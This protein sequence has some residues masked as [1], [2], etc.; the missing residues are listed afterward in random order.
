[1]NAFQCVCEVRAEKVFIVWSQSRIIDAQPPQGNT[2]HQDELQARG[3]RLTCFLTVCVRESVCV[4]HMCVVCECGDH[5]CVGA[6]SG[7]CVTW[8]W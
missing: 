7:R 1:M 6:I 5:G 3:G 4:L 2:G 8:G